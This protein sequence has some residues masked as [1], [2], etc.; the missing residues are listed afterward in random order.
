[1]Y[2]GEP[3][4]FIAIGNY[5][6]DP[7]T[8]DI[9]HN[10]LWQSSDVEVATINSAGLALAND[11]RSTTITA[12]GKASNGADIAGTSHVQVQAVADG[13][14]L[15]PKLS[16]YEVGLG[17]G[18]V[19][20]SDGVTSCTTSAASGAAC[21]ANYILGTKVT[22]TA[23]PADGST[24]GVGPLTVPRHGYI[25]SNRHEQQRTSWRHIQHIQLMSG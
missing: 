25:L 7:L 9:T 12:L 20:S 22:L 11:V 8:A 15:L 2:L 6:T 23:T 10:V 18:T 21:T 17:S 14:V 4:Q 24:F 1:L 16:V 13:S 19:T 3:A 5:N